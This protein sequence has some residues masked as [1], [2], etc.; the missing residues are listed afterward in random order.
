MI[1]AS[2]STSC[3]ECRPVQLTKGAAVP[4]TALSVAQPALLPRRAESGVSFTYTSV[5]HSDII[6]SAFAPF[7]LKMKPT[8]PTPLAIRF[9]NLLILIKQQVAQAVKQDAD[10]PTNS[11]VGSSD[12]VEKLQSLSHKLQLWACRLVV[13]RPMKERLVGDV[14]EALEV[15][16]SSLCDEL[17]GIFSAIASHVIK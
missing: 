13:R 17:H 14:L 6:F 15:S 5:R 11:Q 1:S 9:A 16:N 7:M 2:K 12:R 4:R 8:Y 10:R 3:L